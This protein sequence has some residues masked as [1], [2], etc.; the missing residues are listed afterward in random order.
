MSI[1]QSI[2][3][4][5]QNSP[6][7]DEKYP[8]QV[9]LEEKMRTQG[10]D[11]FWANANKNKEKGNET[12]TRS[13]ARLLN[14][15]LTPMV[16]AIDDFKASAKSGKAGRKHTALQYIDKLESDAIALI[17]VRTVLDEI[18]SQKSL[19]QVSRDIA[20]MIQDELSYR[21]FA[22]VDPVSHS[23]L[24][25][26]H[27]K[28]NA[29]QRVRTV[30]R[31]NMTRRQI[32]MED[33]AMDV[34]IK[35][36]S[37]LVELMTEGTGLIKLVTQTLSKNNRMTVI[38]PT[39][40]TMQWI[41]EENNR[42][43]VM[44]PLYLP[45]VI[46]PK[47]WSDPFT[48]GY[49]TPRVRRLT[50]MKGWSLSKEY[51]DELAE[52][53]LDPV[54]DAVNSMQ[55]TEWC[56]NNRVLD[57]VKT[58]WNTG[59]QIGGIPSAD[60]LPLPPKP[61]FLIDKSIQKED[62]TEEQLDQFKIWKREAGDIHAQ[63]AKLKS[64]RLQF[65]KTLYIAELFEDEHTIFFPHQMD[66]R[67]RAYA[68]PLFLNP[69]SSDLS[70]GL[71]EFAS[72]VPVSD[73]TD[74][75]WLAIHGANVYGKDKCSLADRV[76]WI[77]EHEHEI[78]AV[79]EDPYS[80]RFWCDADKPFQFLAFCFDWAGYKKEGYGYMSCL[81]VQMDGSC[82]GLQHFSAMLRDDIGGKA[83]NLLPAD[84][85]ED[86]Y[87]I[88]AER[89]LEKVTEDV[90]SDNEIVAALAQGWLKHGIDRKVAK[91]PVMTLSY[92]AT[93]FGFREQVFE[94]TVKPFKMKV[95]RN[96]FPWEGSGWDAATYMGKLIWD[97]TGEVVIAARGA[98]EWLQFAAKVAS[99]E[100]LPVRWYTPDGLPIVQS[101]P[102]VN[103]KRIELTFGG[104]RVVLTGQS[105]DG[106]K[107]NKSKQA[108]GIAPNWTHSMDA[109]HM[110]AT[111]RTCWDAGIRSF[112]LIH[113][114]YGTHAGNAWAMA[115][116]LRDEFVNMYS[117]DVLER[118]KKELE[119]Q[120]PEGKAL[121]DIPC[122]GNLDLELV[123]GSEYFFA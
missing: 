80:N 74:A 26:K 84:K 28:M 45:T 47:P 65:V 91:R 64:L 40:N 6:E 67:G 25:R 122:K 4:S 66:F 51:L 1:T 104:K 103:T 23:Y 3:D 71:L 92:G 22:E 12:K 68:V 75:N 50:L 108:S 7:W 85:P 86:V 36:G 9:E 76:K 111:V 52:H 21:H 118:F 106:K 16:E 114:S 88:V 99:K 27:K 24:V 112:S 54:Y 109:S 14:A 35:V 113:D 87:G 69:Q 78:L 89:V 15:S 123:R 105:P 41:Q 119:D 70:K 44:S 53:D 58:L 46:P 81:P 31:L 117:V 30:M 38:E 93:E 107:L 121:P 32:E 115:T 39:E 49:W 62:W 20:R 8:Q 101:Y 73:E 17:T 110:R 102:R 29:P 43:A 77:A 97:C 2:I 42:C 10:V 90:R 11:R 120:L 57:V 18:T 60:D 61:P 5:I 33:W 94:D 56:I 83:V 79:S 13:V 96:G 48:G 63:N 98:M 72:T 59:S 37:K 19:T 95:G 82:N 100:E 55:S 116:A 34:E